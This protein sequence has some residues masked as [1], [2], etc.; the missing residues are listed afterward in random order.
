MGYQWGLAGRGASCFS[1]FG[2][3]LM[4]SQGADGSVQDVNE[5]FPLK[6]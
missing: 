2:S 6:L 1:L 3:V 5:T 4:V